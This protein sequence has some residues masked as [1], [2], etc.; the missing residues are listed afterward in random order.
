MD[1][2]TEEAIESYMY[3]YNPQLKH[4]YYI[5]L[6]IHI[7]I[8]HRKI[9]EIVIGAISHP[10]PSEVHSAETVRQILNSSD[11]PTAGLPWPASVTL[12]DRGEA[13]RLDEEAN[14]MNISHTPFHSTVLAVIHT[15]YQ[16]MYNT[17]IQMNIPTES[18]IVWMV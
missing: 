1:W 18:H 16:V 8:I 11:T 5:M 6:Y 10:D 9:Y 17:C 12:T 14:C 13:V 7:C 2:A 4:E 3:I 15:Q